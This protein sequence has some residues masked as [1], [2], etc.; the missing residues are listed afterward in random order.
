MIKDCENNIIDISFGDNPISKVYSGD[1]LIWEKT[2]QDYI[3]DG[4]FLHLDGADCAGS[5]WV[6]KVSGKVLSLSGSVPSVSNGGVVFNGASVFYNTEIVPPLYTAA[7]IEVVVNNRVNESTGKWIVGHHLNNGVCYTINTGLLESSFRLST[8]NY[9]RRKGS[10]RG[11]IY[12][13]SMTTSYN[14]ANKVV[15]ALGSNDYWGL[16]YC[17]SVGGKITNSSFGRDKMCKSTVYQI[18][19]YNRKLTQEEILY[20][21]SID[22]KKYNIS[23]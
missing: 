2:E 21:Q 23:V 4:L 5:T 11:V 15:A 17:F 7:T 12:T 18:R 3:K 16:G 14:I 10:K 20:N 19:I 22:I 13:H 8:T 1:S 6:D 9:Q